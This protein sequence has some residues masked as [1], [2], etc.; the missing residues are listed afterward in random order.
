M[1]YCRRRRQRA[2]MDQ[3]CLEARCLRGVRNRACPT[4]VREPFGPP[5]WPP[6][7]M[8]NRSTIA[9][10][11]CVFRR[12]RFPTST[13]WEDAHDASPPSSSRHDRN[14]R[15]WR[16]CTRDSRWCRGIRGVPWSPTPSW[17]GRPSW[18]PQPL[19]P[20]R[21]SN[22]GA[23]RGIIPSVT[24]SRAIHPPMSPG[25]APPGPSPGQASV[26]F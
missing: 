12:G 26:Q 13:G 2:V 19:A 5:N 9:P 14:L 20:V 21:W 18:R 24:S 6:P 4:A 25:R 7:G 17:R 10:A 23:G 3:A 16:D 1:F 8:E 11:G 15:A 22:P